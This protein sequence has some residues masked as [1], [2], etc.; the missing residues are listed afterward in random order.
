MK[1]MNRHIRA[2]ARVVAAVAIVAAAASLVAGQPG[3]SSRLDVV[4]VVGHWEHSVEG[5]E[6]VVLSDG[7]KWDGKTGPNLTKVARELFKE[8]RPLFAANSA[9]A[10]AFPLAVAQGVDDFSNGELRIRFKLVG[11][12]SDQTA[13]LA[14][15]IGP[16]ADYIYVRYNTKDGNVAVWE[17]LNGKRNVLTHG[18]DHE[19]LPLNAWHDL[20]VRVAGRTVSGTVNGKLKVEHELP[21][22]V[23]GRVGF[24]T[25]RDAVSAFKA[26]QVL[27]AA[28]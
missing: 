28:R 4:P 18:T 7:R 23:R 21:R 8:P 17:F 15:G 6:P 22:P 27:P 20:A 9:P 14:F 24:W 25:K 2:I 13:G 3:A 5:A 10:T 1:P 16:A 12:E 19:Q 11:G 26:L